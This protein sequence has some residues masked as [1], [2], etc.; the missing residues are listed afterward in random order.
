V[1]ASLRPG[2]FTAVLGGSGAG[3]TILLN[4][5]AERMTASSTRN[6]AITFNGQPGLQGVRYAYV[7]QQDV[8]LPTLTVRETLRYSAELRLPGAVDRSQLVDEVI[9]ELGLKEC[10]DNRVGGCSGGERRR[11]SIGV[12]MLGNPSVLLFDE[13]TTGLDAASAF[14]LVRTLKNLAAK[15]RTVITTIHQPR[16]EI[17]DLFD[18]L[19]VMSRG[20][21]VYSGPRQDCMPWFTDIGYTLPPFVNPAEFI[22]DLAAID[23]RTPALEE[24]SCTRVD[25][26]KAKWKI[27]AEKKFDTHTEKTPMDAATRRGDASVQRVGFSRQLRVLTDRSFKV[28][29]RDPMGMAAALLEAVLMS[30]VT[31][32]IFYNIPRDQSGIRSREGALYTVAGLQGYL[33]IIFEVYRL[34]VDIPTFD[35][36]H[37]EGCV[38][39]LPFL[40][41]RR[42]SRLFIEDIPVPLLFSVIF[43]FMAGFDREASKFG[44]F[45]AICLIGHYIAVSAAMTCVTASRSFS[46]ASF[47]ANMTFTLQTL[48]CG[49][50]IQLN[51]IPVYVRWLQYLAYLVSPSTSRYS[52]RW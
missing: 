21:P 28:S 18:N 44:I 6:G 20:S 46:G 17:W 23:N 47:I 22:V 5:L 11:V 14:Q 51:T 40:L 49:F 39:A 9:L 42:I 32:Y 33:F 2:T 30:I 16:S 3:K 43:Y 45:F 10:A 36:E 24:E 19:M 8:L 15:G 37:S 41:A 13:P 12:Q 35:R 50:F 1:S 4:T 34:T 7:M 26:L 52:W 48:G 27:E 29:Y 31:G 25:S 38:D